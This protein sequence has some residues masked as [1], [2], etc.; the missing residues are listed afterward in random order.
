[1]FG[2]DCQAENIF[3]IWAYSLGDCV[4]ACKNMQYVNNTDKVCKAVALRADMDNVKVLA[5]NCFLKTGCSM[6]VPRSADVAH[7][8][9]LD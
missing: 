4:Q 2:E 7:A 3:S 1:M 5:R 6:P 9:L 8:I